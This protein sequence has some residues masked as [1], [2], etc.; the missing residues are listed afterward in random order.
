VH[1][2]TPLF[3]DPKRKVALKI[4]NKRRFSNYEDG[5]GDDYQLASCFFSCSSHSSH[6]G[7]MLL[8]RHIVFSRHVLV[9]I[10]R[11]QKKRIAQFHCGFMRLGF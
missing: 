1:E 2:F 8:Y 3:R 9:K 10:R 5:S 4:E 6:N 7:C 11:M